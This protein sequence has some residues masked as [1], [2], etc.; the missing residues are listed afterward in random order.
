MPSESVIVPLMLIAF[1]TMMVFAW[2]GREMGSRVA[3]WLRIGGL[4]VLVGCMDPPVSTVA[5][6]FVPPAE[7]EVSSVVVELDGEK[8]G[9]LEIPLADGRWSLLE[10]VPAGMPPVDKWHVID[11][12]SDTGSLARYRRPAEVLERERLEIVAEGGGVR[13]EHLLMVSPTASES[14]RLRASSPLR[15]VASLSRVEVLT[16]APDRQGA[17]PRRLR[18]TIDG[19]GSSVYSPDELAGL[20]RKPAPCRPEHDGGWALADL[21]AL[22]HD[23]DDVA[24]VTLTDRDNKQTLV[25]T[26][27][28]LRDSSSGHVLRIKPNKQ[29][30]WSFKE[31]GPPPECGMVSVLRQVDKVLIETGAAR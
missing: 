7:V 16:V 24:S 9:V 25:L 22:R 28:Q 14:A 6:E 13:V 11:I 3:C 30:D 2:L 21:I 23:L 5:P 26:G 18:T 10:V 8:V 19:A 31:L 20:T 15:T 17:D 27:A 12:H 4:A 29:G 1:S